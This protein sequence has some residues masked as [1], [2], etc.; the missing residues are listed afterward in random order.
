MAFIICDDHN[1]SVDADGMGGAGQRA[2][3]WRPPRSSR[4]MCPLAEGLACAPMRSG[5]NHP[6]RTVLMPLEDGANGRAL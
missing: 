6:D 5:H 1:L 3:R 4:R 2:R